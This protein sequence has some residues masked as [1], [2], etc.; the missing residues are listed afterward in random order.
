MGIDEAIFSGIVIVEGIVPFL[1][2]VNGFIAVIVH[3]RLHEL[4][5][6]VPKFH[7]ARR[8]ILGRLIQLGP[9]HAGI[10]P[11]VHLSVHHCVGKVGYGGISGDRILDFLA[12]RQ[13][14]QRRDQKQRQR[15][16]K[17]HEASVLTPLFKRQTQP[18]GD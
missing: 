10:F 4:P 15:G 3:L 6:T 11:V 12:L 1:K 17:Q 8:A 7:H 14:R 2:G 13:F 18:G 16:K 9:H 5:H